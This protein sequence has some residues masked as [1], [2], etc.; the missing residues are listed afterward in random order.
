MST[1]PF[2]RHCLNGGALFWGRSLITEGVVPPHVIACPQ[3]SRR[4]RE[5]LHILDDGRM[6]AI[7]EDVGDDVRF[8][9]RCWIED[10]SDRELRDP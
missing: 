9:T 1:P 3:C 4:W 10:N 6:L 5:T 8:T 7:L 2:R